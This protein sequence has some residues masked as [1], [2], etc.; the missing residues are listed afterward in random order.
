MRFESTTKFLKGSANVQALVRPKWGWQFL[1]LASYK[2]SI[3]CEVE[4]AESS[5]GTFLML[6]VGREFK[7]HDTF[8]VKQ[9]RQLQEAIAAL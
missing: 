2:D 9:Q 8:T 5:K 1:W 4:I 6:R 7:L 3:P